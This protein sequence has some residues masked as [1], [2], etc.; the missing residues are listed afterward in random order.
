MA[1]KDIHIALHNG[2][3]LAAG[4][5]KGYLMRALRSTKAQ[6]GALWP[7]LEDIQ[8]VRYLNTSFWAENAVVDRPR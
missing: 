8:V 2:Q 3:I 7:P 5:H 1:S 6:K 4:T